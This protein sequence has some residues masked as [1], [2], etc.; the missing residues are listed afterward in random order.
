MWY[1]SVSSSWNAT[2]C[3]FFRRTYSG[4]VSWLMVCISSNPSGN[5]HLHMD[6]ARPLYF[7]LN[8]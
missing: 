8:P 6:S 7:L 2:A 5:S 3:P 1:W 4:M